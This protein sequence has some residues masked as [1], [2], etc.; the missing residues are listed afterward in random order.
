MRVL[1]LLTLG[2]TPAHAA[3]IFCETAWF[4]R[5]LFYA[6]AG[7]CFDTPL[8]RAVFGER[9]EGAATLGPDAQRRIEEI[10]AY[11][12]SGRGCTVNSENE[13]FERL[14][15]L[16][17]RRRLDVHPLRSGEE[18][19]CGDWRG[20]P[21]VLRAA[22]SSTARIVGTVEPGEN[23]GYSHQ[24]EGSWEMVEVYAPRPDARSELVALGWLDGG[25]VDNALC[26]F[27][28]G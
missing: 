20:E 24:W 5:N 21:L 26:G 13:T 6:K 4:A 23:I 28:A 3:N 14:D 7:H 22:P 2:C 16:A 12:V 8:G 19:S 25:T 9:C 18:S 10:R 1:V 27:M 17:L 11:E 15:A